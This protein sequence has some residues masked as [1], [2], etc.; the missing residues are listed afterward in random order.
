MREEKIQSDELIAREKIIQANL[1]RALGASSASSRALLQAQRK[2]A[3]PAKEGEE[4]ERRDASKITGS[5]SNPKAAL[6]RIA[7]CVPPASLSAAL[8]ALVYTLC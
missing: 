4:D 5:F 1:E 3:K 6:K 2:K 7:K 8:I